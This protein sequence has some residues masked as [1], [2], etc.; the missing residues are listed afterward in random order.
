MSFKKRHEKAGPINFS[1]V[2]I[3]ADNILLRKSG[4]AKIISLN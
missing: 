4:L 3:M 1:H 2:A